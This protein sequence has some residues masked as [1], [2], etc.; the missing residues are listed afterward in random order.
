MTEYDP[1]TTFWFVKWWLLDDLN[2]QWLDYSRHRFKESSQSC[3]FERI[4]YK[5]FIFCLQWWRIDPGTTSLEPCG[6]SYEHHPIEEHSFSQPCPIE[7]SR[8]CALVEWR[9]QWIRLNTYQAQKTASS[10]FMHLSNQV[11]WIVLSCWAVLNEPFEW[12]WHH[13]AFAKCSDLTLKV[14]IEMVP[15]KTIFFTYQP[16]REVAI[17][18][19]HV[20]E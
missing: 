3:D 5:A 4:L 7:D 19:L 10:D 11:E 20:M 2:N 15:E 1:K 17:V 8:S 6:M 12:C 13:T 16:F 14:F 18:I 9:V